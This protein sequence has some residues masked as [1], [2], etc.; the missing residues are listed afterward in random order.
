MNDKIKHKTKV[1]ILFLK[2]LFAYKVIIDII[3][4]L[5]IKY[6]ISNF[7]CSEI[8]ISNV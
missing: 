1:K 7:K 2:I 3:E 4:I 6:A 8:E 5:E